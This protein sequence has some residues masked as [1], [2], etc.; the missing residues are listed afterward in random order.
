MKYNPKGFVRYDQD[1]YV[2]T[3]Y[4]RV[5]LYWDIYMQ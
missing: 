1:Q 2:K 5:L 4:T 3:K